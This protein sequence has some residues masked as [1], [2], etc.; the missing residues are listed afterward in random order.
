MPIDELNDSPE[1]I[2]FLTANEEY[3]RRMIPTFALEAGIDAIRGNV[4]IALG[5]IG[6]PAAVDSLGRTLRHKNTQI[7]AYSAWALGRIGGAQARALLGKALTE[8]KEPGVL[9]EI[10]SALAGDHGSN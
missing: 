8:E 5:N 3:F 1:L 2:P 6:D 9:D 10:K 7:R 4:V